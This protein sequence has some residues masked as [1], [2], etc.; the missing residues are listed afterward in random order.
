MKPLV[1]PAY[2]VPPGYAPYGNF[3]ERNW[4]G[5]PLRADLLGEYP[6]LWTRESI[7][8]V[9]PESFSGPLYV[10]GEPALPYG[11]VGTVIRKPRV[12]FLPRPDPDV[13]DIY[14]DSY[15]ALLDAVL[16]DCVADGITVFANRANMIAGAMLCNVPIKNID[17]GGGTQLVV[18]LAPEEWVGGECFTVHLSDNSNL[19][20][21]YEE[22]GV[23]G[24][25]Q[26][27]FEAA[28]AQEFVPRFDRYGVAACMAGFG[29]GGLVMPRGGGVGGSSYE[30]GWQYKFDQDA[31]LQ[32]ELTGM[33]EAGDTQRARIAAR[34]S[35]LPANQRQQRFNTVNPWLQAMYN[36]PF[37][38]GQS[39]SGPSIDASP[40]WGEQQIQGRVNLMRGTNDAATAGRTRNMRQD[41]AGRGFGSNSPLAQALGVQMQGQNLATNTQGEN[42]LRWTAAEGNKAH[43]LKAQ[44]AQEQQYANR[45]QEDIERRRMASQR[46]NAIIAAMAGIV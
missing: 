21:L 31:A 27:E 10:L 19:Y 29:S 44:T 7:L 1:L 2:R 22:G 46:Q 5:V 11:T 26:A 37:D 13:D 23:P 35:T 34:A 6:L 4:Q 42:D 39:G 17:V 9:F 25:D 38:V 30:P 16:A 36:E 45:M 28:L 40:I 14:N 18:E 15:Q 32:R 41:L 20:D 33:R 12:L 8:S 43:V 24:P 3:E